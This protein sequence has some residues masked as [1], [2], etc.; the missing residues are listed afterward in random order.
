MTQT[1]SLS[2][3]QSVWHVADLTLISGADIARACSMLL[4][5]SDFYQ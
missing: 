5:A 2:S 1:P 4:I 3:L